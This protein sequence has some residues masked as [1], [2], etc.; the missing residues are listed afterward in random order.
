M[1]ELF[2]SDCGVRF[3]AKRPDKRYC[4]PACQARVGRRRRNEQTDIT[5]AGRNCL[6]C[7]KHFDIT[8]PNTNRR[9]C[10][11]NCARESARSQRRAFHR[12]RPGIQKI[13]NSRRPFG[14]S[15]IARLRRKYPDLPSACEACGE[16]RILE[17]AH[18]P[19]FKRNGAWRIVANTQRHMF[20]LL[21][22][23]C[24]KLLDSGIC[25]KQDFHL[26]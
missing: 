22:P 9:Y 19:E 25:T 6:L 23:T 26:S 24:H 2:C 4:S 13:Y 15:V 11:E 16:D 18:K 10:S 20:W 14:D 7:G 21:C 5:K 17:V 12:R 1:Y 8:P 3:S